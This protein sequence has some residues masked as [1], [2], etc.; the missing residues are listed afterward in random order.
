[1][2]TIL[3]SVSKNQKTVAQNA[4]DAFC[5]RVNR[6][7]ARQ[8]AGV[9]IQ[10]DSRLDLLAFTQRAKIVTAAEAAYLYQEASPM[11]TWSAE[12][13]LAQG[14]VEGSIEVLGA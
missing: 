3:E 12:E 5:S 6:S 9:S 10:P 8:G 4:V 2:Y 13:L 11:G 14:I 1:M 7:L